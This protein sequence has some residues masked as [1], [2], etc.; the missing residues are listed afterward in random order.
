MFWAVLQVVR[1]SVTKCMAEAEKQSMGSIG[2]PSLGTG[3]LGYP[4]DVVARTMFEAA[5]DYGRQHPNSVISDVFFILHK[6]DDKLQKVC[7]HFFLFFVLEYFGIDFLSKC[8]IA[9]KVTLV[10]F[11]LYFVYSCKLFK[12]KINKI[13]KKIKKK[14]NK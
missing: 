12:K 5:L 2:F 9:Y 10:L 14:I 1:D 8:Q 6:K 3:N 13:L 11:G 7:C 4:A